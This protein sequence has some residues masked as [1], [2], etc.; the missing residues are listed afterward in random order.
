M[1]PVQP[2]E[3]VPWV[4]LPAIVQ[5]QLEYSAFLG[6][7]KDQGVNDLAQGMT[8]TCFFFCHYHVGGV[9]PVRVKLCT[10]S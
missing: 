10:V 4:L 7:R 2:A 6:Y 1:K 3:P 9:L 5:M 8:D